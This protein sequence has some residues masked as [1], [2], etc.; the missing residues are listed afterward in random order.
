MYY[1]G[2]ILFGAKF[3]KVVFLSKEQGVRGVT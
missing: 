1:G 2:E 3:A